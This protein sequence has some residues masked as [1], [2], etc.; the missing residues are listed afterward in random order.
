MQ[1]KTLAFALAVGAAA[2]VGLGMAVLFGGG[3]PAAPPRPRPAPAPAPTSAAMKYSQTLFRGLVEQDAKA[4]GVPA[5]SPADWAAP[6]PYFDE[7]PARRTLTPG[8]SVATPHLRVSLVIRR[9]EGALGDHGQGQSFR[10]DHLVLRIENRLHR[11][12]AYRVATHV[13][14]P[15]RCEAKGVIAHDAIALAPHETLFRT[16]CLLQRTARLDLE[17]IEVIELPPL[18]YYYVSRLDPALVLYDPRTAAGHASPKGHTCPQTL[19]W[20]E[21]RDGA[22]RGDL[23]WRD[24]IDFY[25]RHNCDELAFFLGYRYR[26]DPNAPLPARPPAADAGALPAP[27][28]AP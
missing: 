20:R 27:D 23:A 21:I 8:E 24:L 10:A 26:T 11:H 18:A 15:A 12:L 22:A 13:A 28:P 4:F 2:I 17:R 6:F 9:E 5:P 25:A 14:D 3:P 19:S 1:G 16:E 7:L